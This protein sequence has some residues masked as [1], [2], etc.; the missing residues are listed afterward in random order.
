MKYAFNGFLFSQRQTGVM[1]FAKEI[2]LGIDKI[3]KKNE[4]VLVVPKYAE[5]VPSLNNIKTIKVGS[6]KGNMWEQKDFA[7]FLKDKDLD[8]VNFN[9]AM[10]LF[11]PG[12]IVIHDIAYKI[13]PEFSTSFH[14][15]L[16][17][18]YHRMIYNRAAKS[19]KPIITV[20]YFSKYQIIDKYHVDPERVHVI[21]NAWQHVNEYGYDDSILDKNGLKDKDYYFSL[22]SLSKMKNTKWFIEVAKKQPDKLFVL[23][24]ARPQNVGDSFAMPKNVIATGFVTDEE[25]KSL[26]RGCKAFVYASIYDGFGIPPLEAL[27][28][29]AQVICSSA[30]CLPEVYRNCVHYIDPYNTDIDLEK[31]L[32][33]PIDDAQ[34]VLNRYSWD[35]SAR[36]FYELIKD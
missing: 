16:S 18:V 5:L 3:C 26:I 17:N 35:K 4:F 31:V 19:N 8:S 22:G 34:E 9:N 29:G 2:L 36:E 32:R 33:E 23:S 28:Q 7:K 30:A 15:K 12:I 20:T 21:G 14:G 24:G 13:H 6:T 1:R 25:V 10:P 27:S 11:R